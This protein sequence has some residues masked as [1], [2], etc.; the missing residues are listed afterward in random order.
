MRSC[1]G[2][3]NTDK[4][5][6]NLHQLNI[7]LQR[8]EITADQHLLRVVRRTSLR[9]AKETYLILQAASV[10]SP[11][12]MSWPLMSILAVVVEE[13]GGKRAVRSGGKNRQW[14]GG[15]SERLSV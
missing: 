1:S 13:G 6:L 2:C 14:R 5:K 9:K 4:E 8:A 12:P 10:E 15:G 11:D 7:M 3:S